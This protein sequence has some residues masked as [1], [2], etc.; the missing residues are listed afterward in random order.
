MAAGIVGD[1]RMRDPVIEQFPG[2]QAGALVARSGL[3]DP[4]MNRNALVVGDVDRRKSGAPI[5]GRQ[6]A[7]VAMGQQIDLCAA[8]LSFPDFGNQPGAMGTDGAA[9]GDVVVANLGGA[10]VGRR[11]ALSARQWIDLLLDSAS[12]DEWFAAI[13]SP[14]PLHFEDSRP[15]PQR[16]EEARQRSGERSAV[17]TGTARI[18][19]LD[20]VVAVSDFRFIGGSMGFAVCER[21]ATAM[22]RAREAKLP[23]VA[24]TCSGGARMQEG[25]V[26]LVQMSKT[27][28]AAQRLH[29][30][31]IPMICVLADPTTGGVFA[32]YATQCDVL[33]AEDGALIAFAGPRVRAVHDA[34]GLFVFD[35]PNWKPV[36]EYASDALLDSM[37]GLRGMEIYCGLIERLGGE[38]RATD[39]WD[40]LLSRGWRVWGHGTDDQHEATDRFIAWNCVQWP[41]AVD[42][43]ASGIIEALGDGRFYASTGVTIEA[44]GVTDEGRRCCVDSDA[45]EIRW[46]V[47]GGRI[48]KKEP[49]GAGS[50]TVD[51]LLR[52]G[53][54]EGD[55]YARAE[56]LGRGAAAAWTQ[57]FWVSRP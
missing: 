17:M 30:A 42:V 25:M 19:G 22:D 44:T 52:A 31:G 26:A 51:E 35:H 15:Y 28:A 16:L 50:L 20:V 49:G 2:G 33:I 53:L 5:D 46:I 9:G 36:P 54:P 56:C 12:F 10:Q 37:E 6:P 7:G 21:V 1:H 40:R 57:P 13:E 29:D 18:G 23:F 47:N 43:D 8:I 38:A 27:A 4:D 48:L 3:I 55:L 45:D 32:S 41:A 34:G 24:L 14:D 39:R 11:E